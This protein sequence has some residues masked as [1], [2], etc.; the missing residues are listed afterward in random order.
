MIIPRPEYPRPQM[1]REN[2]QNLNGEWEFDFDFSNS[3]RERKLFNADKLDKKIIVPFCP[4][5]EL[6][7]VNF[8]DFIPA[9][10]YK[11]DF[12]LNREDVS[13]RVLLHFGAVDYHS[14]VWVNGNKIG[15]HCG[16]FTAFS[17]DITDAVKEG[18]N[19]VVLYA[20][21]D[22][23]SGKQ[24]KGKQ[25]V[26]HFPSGC[27][28]TRTTG[29]WQTVWV[30]SV[31][32][33]YIADYKL[34][35]DYRNGKVSIRAEIKGCTDGYKLIAKTFLSG[36]P[37]GETAV[38]A[39]PFVTL[40]VSL[41]EIDLWEPGN[42]ALYDLTLS[43]ENE[44]GVGDSVDGYFGLRG[45]EVKGK[46]ICINGKPI[47]Q[48]LVLD[49]GFYP[50]GIYTAPSDEALKADIVRCME[51]GFNGARLHEKVFEPRFLYWADKLGYLCWGE[52]ANWGLNIT[53]HEALGIFLSEWMESLDRDFNH[54][55]IIGWCPFNE[56]EVGFD[57]PVSV[58]IVRRIF[59][60]TKMYDT[61]RPAID[62]SGYVHCGKTDVY[63]VHDYEQNV[64]KYAERFGGEINCDY[65]RNRR[66][67]W[68]GSK[69]F[70]VSEYGG[71][72][73][74]PENPEGWGYGA[75]PKSED[76]VGDRYCGLTK[77]LMDNPDICAFCYT[78]PY[79]VEQEQN[80]LYKYDRSPKFSQKIY[81][82]IKET[83]MRKAAIEK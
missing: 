25:C 14:V 44:E 78:Q 69:P 49:Q 1:V 16:G 3:G 47:F 80:G 4:E 48:R 28:Y 34:T 66:Q 74:N 5:S 13:G 65:S 30:E 35:P 17:F 67:R 39:A 15:E 70:F 26:E 36:K 11:R 50:D 6:S 79:D 55:A 19:T 29:I 37:T 46:A 68:D 2:W 42:P 9:V 45:V 24:P 7:G 32:A 53:K 20:E 64:D 23:R 38:Q 82:R 60:V 57:D 43:L 75:T 58:S 62:T 8:K 12:T 41:S 73:W 72:W 83:N 59:E 71:T 33:T 27:N 10:W 56:T 31:P 51:L 21:D 40:E 63:D 61:T 54:P 22:V 76:E 52:Y 81:D 18:V 77:I